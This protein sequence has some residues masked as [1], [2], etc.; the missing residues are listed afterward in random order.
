MTENRINMKSSSLFTLFSAAFLVSSAAYAQYATDFEAPTFTAGATINGQDSWTTGPAINGRVLTG[1]QIAGELTTLGMSPGV[2]VHSG[3]QALLVSGTGASGATI[4]VIPGLGSETEVL[5]NVWVRP[6]TAATNPTGNLFLTM[7]NSAGT[8][9]AAFRFGPAQSIDYGLV[10]SAWVPTGKR[11][12]PNVWYRMTLRANYANKTYDFAIDGI[13]VNT[14]PIP[15]YAATSDS[16]A[17]VRIFRG[18]SQAG[19][20]VDDL[21]VAVA[22]PRHEI[23]WSES[24]PWSGPKLGFVYSTAFDGTAKTAIA[25]NI[26]RPIGIALDVKSG[27]IYWAQDGYDP[28]VTDPLTTSRIVRAN[29]DGSNPTNLFTKEKDGFTNAQMLGL[30]LANG[31]L[32]WTDFSLGVIRG[33]LDG[34]GYTVLGGSGNSTNRYCGMAVDLVRR[35]VYFSEPQG[36]GILW[37]MDMDGKNLVVID[38]QI[39]VD[40]DDWAV[41]SMTLDADNRYLYF[42]HAMPGAD[43]VIRMNLDGS[44]KTVLVADTGREPLGIA[45]G[46]TNTMYWV[47]GGG[48][49]IGTANRDGTLNNNQLIAPLDTATGFGLATVCVPPKRE[50]FWSETGGWAAA[51]LGVIYSAAFDGSDKTVVATNI[52]RP[53]GIALDVKNNY[54]YWAQDGYDG[55]NTS[56]IVRANLGG[57]N[58]TN[59]FTFEKDGFSNAQMLGLDLANGQ[60]YWTDFSLGVIRGN[61]DGT[62]YTVLGGSGNST[63]RYTA[64]GLDLV[65]RHIFFSEPEGPGILWRMDMDGKNLVVIDPKIGVDGDDWA[66]NSM[67]VDAQNGYIY[68]P[69]GMTGADQIIRMGLDGSNK[70][71]LVANTGRDPVGIALGPNNTIYWV[72]DIGQSVGTAKTDGTSSLNSLF[73]PLAT[74]S[75][76]GIAAYVPVVSTPA[77]ISG[78]TVQNSTVTITWQGGTPPY[79]L[80]R[81]GSLTQGL[82][83]DVGT[84]TSTIQATDTVNSQPM[85]YRIKSN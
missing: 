24:G 35:Q 30:D 43:Q 1:T 9:A 58:P 61:L 76:F 52:T 2:T 32:Y 44:N 82:W 21:S 66:V 8:R 10:S 19:V 70:T 56:R 25:T 26:T 72:C 47:C 29:F 62:G 11:W 6:L 34:A 69:H 80:Q 12:D 16:F 33:N 41:N 73:A 84:T 23:F 5:L 54:I 64:L 83:L 27:Y 36:P 55:L 51:Q 78:I 65:R 38:P 81:R 59:L 49:S 45:L 74:D 37:R 39:G 77:R 68:Y 3:S 63:N 79:Q 67:T 22:G 20:I 50:L 18:T 14:S 53:I 48:Q 46:P 31:Q 28:S 85:F 60:L 4:R 7:E 13:Q 40:G 17:Q 75:G 57:S 71:V 42:P 15:F